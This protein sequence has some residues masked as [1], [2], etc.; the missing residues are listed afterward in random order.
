MAI[1]IQIPEALLMHTVTLAKYTGQGRSGPTFDTPVEL[2]GFLDE[3]T[4]RVVGPGGQERTSMA[5]LHTN[6]RIDA[7]PMSRVTF[8]GETHEVIARSVHDSPFGTL[9]T[10]EMA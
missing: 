1:R 9:T 4:S 3:R 6:G 5:R 8:H 2:K 10:I 7:P